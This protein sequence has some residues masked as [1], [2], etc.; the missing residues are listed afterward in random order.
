MECTHTKWTRKF[1]AAKLQHFLVAISFIYSDNRPNY[2]VRNISTNQGML[3]IGSCH[4]NSLG[5]AMNGANHLYL[6]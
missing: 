1:G 6:L 5:H 4:P 2:M 3:V